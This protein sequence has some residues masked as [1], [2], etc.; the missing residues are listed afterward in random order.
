MT[1]DE[2]IGALRDAEAHGDCV[3]EDIEAAADGI[4][5]LF[6]PSPAATPSA[7]SP[8]APGFHIVLQVDGVIVDPSR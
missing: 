5:R 7:T 6:Y 2:V 3:P 1:R 4:M 8:S